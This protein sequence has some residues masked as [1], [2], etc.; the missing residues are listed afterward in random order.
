MSTAL[1]RL[2]TDSPPLPMSAVAIAVLQ[3]TPNACFAAEEFFKASISNEH[4]RRAYG[5]IVGRF[6]GWCDKRKIELH[7]VT[8]GIAGDYFGQIKGSEPTKNRL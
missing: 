7:N 1:V 4:T 2:P 6:L 5:R 3:R 8:P